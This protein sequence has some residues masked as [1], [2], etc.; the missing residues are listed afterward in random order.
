MICS[1]SFDLS[2]DAQDFPKI[3]NRLLWGSRQVRPAM[4]SSF[5]VVLQSLEYCVIVWP[6]VFL[7]I[8]V[9]YERNVGV[10]FLELFEKVRVLGV[11][12]NRVHIRMVKYV[13]N[14]I[15]F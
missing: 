15:H 11:D 5:L 8:C 6:G 2:V 12:N 1:Y 10:G 4:A 7:G 13:G 3:Y 9:Y 14:V